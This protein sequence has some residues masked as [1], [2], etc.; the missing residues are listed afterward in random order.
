MYLKIV[1]QGA[2]TLNPELWTYSKQFYYEAGEN[3]LRRLKVSNLGCTLGLPK[4]HQ[5]HNCEETE[6]NYLD[7]QVLH[8]SFLAPA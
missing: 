7:W 6:A 3:T 2:P 8:F 5:K 1:F 4:L